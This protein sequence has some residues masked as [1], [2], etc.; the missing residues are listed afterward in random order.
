[1]TLGGRNEL[2]AS[3]GQEVV[4]F[5][6]GTDK[7]WWTKLAVLQNHS[8]LFRTQVFWLTAWR[9]A[10]G[11]CLSTL[12]WLLLVTLRSTKLAGDIGNKRWLSDDVVLKVLSLIFL[13]S[14]REVFIWM[15]RFEWVIVGILADHAKQVLPSI[16]FTQTST[17]KTLVSSGSSW[18]KSLL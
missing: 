12:V 17:W 10:T 4:C 14:C 9:P 8:S 1:V 3:T 16:S 2:V 15:T 13:S 5:P 11:R 6:K 7:V 18:F